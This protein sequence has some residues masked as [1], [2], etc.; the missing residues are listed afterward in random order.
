MLQQVYETYVLDAVV[1]IMVIAAV[2]REYKSMVFNRI[3]SITN[4]E[5]KVARTES[6]NDSPGL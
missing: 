3:D 2:E 5:S 4:G 6:R 1:A